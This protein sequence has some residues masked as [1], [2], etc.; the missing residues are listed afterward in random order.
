MRI[1]LFE[2]FM[3]SLNESN[4]YKEL[5]EAFKS[6]KLKELGKMIGNKTMIDSLLHSQ[7]ISISEIEDEDIM[8]M[9]PEETR[10]L[11]DGFV[12]FY[13]SRSEKKNPYSEFDDEIKKD[14]LVGYRENGG[15]GAVPYYSISTL[16]YDHYMGGKDQFTGKRKTRVSRAETTS[17]KTVDGVGSLKR[18]IE[19]SDEAYVLPVLILKS[20]HDVRALRD[21]RSKAKKGLIHPSQFESIVQQNI[22]RYQTILKDK[23]LKNNKVE[24]L[25]KKAVE[26]INKKL[27]AGI[28]FDAKSEE[29]KKF[30]DMAHQVTRI[31]D[32]FRKYT[33]SVEELA[34]TKEYYSKQGSSDSELKSALKWHDIDIAR[35]ED[36]IVELV[37]GYA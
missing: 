4:E 28:K 24:D 34:K 22:I 35:G 27:M 37:K 17:K 12:I 10:R 33:N 19:L 3:D 11:K 31:L 32:S 18:I 15:L 29:I 5:N 13:I 9:K 8:V 14:S 30:S 21:E 26:N 16:R 6:S 2:E 1:K 20:K 36:E 25:V 7:K 23:K